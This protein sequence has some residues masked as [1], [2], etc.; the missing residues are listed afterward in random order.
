M[1]RS[2]QRI[3]ATGYVVPGPRNRLLDSGTAGL[4]GRLRSRFVDRVQ[5]VAEPDAAAVL[6]ALVVGTRHLLT[7]AQWERYAATGTS[8]LMAISGLHVGLAAGGA[9]LVF[10]GFA[11][12]AGSPRNAHR[13]AVVGA[14]GVAVAYAAL[15]GFAVPARRAALMLTEDKGVCRRLR[16]TERLGLN[17]ANG[18]QNFVIAPRVNT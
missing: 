16:L 15:S 11:G 4:P 17:C 6:A 1:G 14:L 18:Y 7:D 9:Y 3:G 5:R 8:H 10:L 12:L 2:T 13:G